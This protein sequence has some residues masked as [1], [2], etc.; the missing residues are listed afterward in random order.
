MTTENRGVATGIDGELNPHVIGP[1]PPAPQVTEPPRLNLL[2]WRHG[3]ERRWDYPIYL[4]S[5]PPRSIGTGRPSGSISWRN[6]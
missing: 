6:T 4:R 2:R 5:R 3:F 1:I